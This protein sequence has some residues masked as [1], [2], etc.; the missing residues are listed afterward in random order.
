MSTTPPKLVTESGMP[1]WRVIYEHM[2]VESMPWF[3]P[4][5][6]P[7]LARAID[8]L[9]LRGG[10]FL[11]LGTGPGTQ[12]IELAR[13]GFV[14]TGTDVSSAAIAQAAVRARGVSVRFVVDDLLAT[15]LREEFDAIFDR[16]CFHV[17][18]E[19]EH[20]R[21]LASLLSLLK[22]G[23]LFFLKCF[24]VAEPGDVGPRRF[25]PEDLRRIFGGAL[26]IESIEETVYYGNVS[27]QSP[28]RHQPRSLFAVMRRAG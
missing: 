19:K 15:T 24:S 4:H 21:Y 12:A 5:L 14:V 27:E 17:F 10:T 20:P 3:N 13:L 11:D 7:D 9:G 22:P 25:A 8:A 28:I 16:G 26:S 1:D 6:D 18:D 2:P 23:G